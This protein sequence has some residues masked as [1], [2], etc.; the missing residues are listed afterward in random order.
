MGACPLAGDKIE[1]G[2]KECGAVARGRAA[3]PVVVRR[4]RR[5]ATALWRVAAAAVPVPSGARAAP[6]SVAIPAMCQVLSRV[7]M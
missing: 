1:T 3:G 6:G 5:A 7:S 4:N 2:Y